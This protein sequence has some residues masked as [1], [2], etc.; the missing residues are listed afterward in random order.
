MQSNKGDLFMKF[1][2]SQVKYSHYDTKRG[3][4]LPENPSIE[5]AELVGIILGDGHLH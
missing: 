1:E 5:L 4:K 2:L 3:I